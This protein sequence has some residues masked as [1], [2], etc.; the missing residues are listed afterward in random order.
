VIVNIGSVAA[1]HAEPRSAAYSAAKAGRC[2]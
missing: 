1:R 2:S